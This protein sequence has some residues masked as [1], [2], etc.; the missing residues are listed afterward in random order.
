MMLTLLSSA[1]VKTQEVIA[2]PKWPKPKEQVVDE[3]EKNCTPES[4]CPALWEWLNRLYVLR[5]QLAYANQTS[6]SSRSG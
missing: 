2:V 4:K 6:Q 1:C 5:D 3:L